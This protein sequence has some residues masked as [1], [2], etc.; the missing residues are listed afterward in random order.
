MTTW[1]HQVK[2]LTVYVY[3]SDRHV[4]ARSVQKDGCAILHRKEQG[5][6]G[7]R[8]PPQD[9]H[10]PR[11]HHSQPVSTISG[12]RSEIVCHSEAILK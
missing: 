4:P 7:S 1:K 12:L 6:S 2:C 9:R 10:L 8:R 5:S 3:S 11:S